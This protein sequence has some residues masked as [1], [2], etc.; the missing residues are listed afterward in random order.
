MNT[1]KLVAA[2]AGLGLALSALSAAAQTPTAPSEIKIGVLYAS[3]GNFAAMSMPEDSGLKFWV[4]EENAK[5]GVFVK[6]YDKR[7]PLKLISYD[8][9][10]NPAT[11]ETLYNQL[12]TQ[13]KVDI[14]VSDAGSVLTAPAVPLGHNHKVLI[15]DSVGVGASLFTKDNPYLVATSL[16]AG[17]DWPR[18]LAQFLIHD[19]PTLGIKRIAMLYATNEADGTQASA[20]RKAIKASGAPLDI[21]YDQG[22]PTAT[23]NYSVLINNIKAT[24]PDAVIEFGY[25]N[26]DITFLENLQSNAV[27]FKFLF[28]VF[29]GLETDHFLQTVGAKALEYGTTYVTSLN[30]NYKPE[31]GLNLE[32]YKKAWEAKNKGSKISFSFNAVAGYNTGL[33][34][35]SAL[36][37]TDS[38]DQL[39]LRKAV[40]D[41][42]GKLKTLDGTFKIDDAGNQ[43][44]EI[45]PLGQ[46][47]PNGEG[48]VKLAV[49][50][51]HNFSTGKIV[52]PAK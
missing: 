42:S 15:F 17:T 33:V 9:Q 19:G 2:M 41:L 48:G 52:Y 39:A 21:V 29:P 27:K 49:L 51:P 20:V 37:T 4:D 40:S 32:Q 18:Y 14:L 38:M 47:I 5:G 6:P 8:D 35:Q 16:P 23:N 30:V 10:S 28:N 13:D 26:N 22:A 25:P 31:V 44:G 7:I 1:R 45:M 36:K 24:N 34:I 43:I 12:V 3:S 46:L 11:A 50:Y